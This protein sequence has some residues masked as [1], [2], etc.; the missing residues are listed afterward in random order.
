M[1]ALLAPP[2]KRIDGETENQVNPDFTEDPRAGGKSSV[3]CHSFHGQRGAVRILRFRGGRLPKNPCARTVL[4]P[5]PFMAL[6]SSLH[7]VSGGRR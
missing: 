1:S 2:V 4:S 5:P 7:D 6:S 3:T